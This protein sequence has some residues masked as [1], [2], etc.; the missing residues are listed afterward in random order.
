M[1]YPDRIGRDGRFHLLAPGATVA[2][3][4]HDPDGWDDR[5]PRG[6]AVP[7]CEDC[8]RRLLAD[9]EARVRRFLREREAAEEASCAR[10]RRR[11]PARGRRPARP[12]AGRLA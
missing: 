6:R 12:R 1:T 3:C 11:H 2:R 7:V 9:S 10:C 4:G 8:L 5:T